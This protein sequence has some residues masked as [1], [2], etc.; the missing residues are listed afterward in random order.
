MKKENPAIS[1]EALRV[2]QAGSNNYNSSI[3]DVAS[4]LVGT[5]YQAIQN[6]VVISTTV[7]A[8]SKAVAD[9]CLKFEDLIARSDQHNDKSFNAAYAELIAMAL[10]IFNACEAGT[11]VIGYKQGGGL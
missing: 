10:Y 11:V 1:N 4:E 2:Q 6:A 5:V 8:E 3:D 9:Y 7:A